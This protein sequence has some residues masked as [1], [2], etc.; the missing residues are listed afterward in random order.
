VFSGDDEPLDW[1]EL[2]EESE[3]SAELRENE[4][5][6]APAA[7]SDAPPSRSGRMHGER[8]GLMRRG[9]AQ[10][11][12]R[13]DDPREAPVTPGRRAGKPGDA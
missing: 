3:E 4:Q 7:R 5:A 9:L 11:P 10:A 13:R 8:V 6:S 1:A 12:G 2:L